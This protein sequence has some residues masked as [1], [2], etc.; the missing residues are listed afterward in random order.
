MKTILGVLCLAWLMNGCSNQP[1]QPPVLVSTTPAKQ[2][3]STPLGVKYVP[4]G[5][6]SRLVVTPN[7]DPRWILENFGKPASVENVHVQNLKVEDTV[8]ENVTAILTYKYPNRN[9]PKDEKGIFTRKV[10]LN[11]EHVIVVID[12][13]HD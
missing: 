11:E 10:Y 2:M 3:T 8:L 13:W 1:E 4:L 12:F 7:N 5:L 6:D 9:T